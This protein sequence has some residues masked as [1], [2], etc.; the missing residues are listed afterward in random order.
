MQVRYAQL[1][2]LQNSV[3]IPLPSGDSAMKLLA[4]SFLAK[5]A[6]TWNYALAQ[7]NQIIMSQADTHDVP[8]SLV[9]TGD[10]TSHISCWDEDKASQELLRQVWRCK[11]KRVCIRTFMV[12]V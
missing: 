11:P 7:F 9:T 2:C 3:V 8:A 12:A 4:L 10:T 1:S 6:K 5:L